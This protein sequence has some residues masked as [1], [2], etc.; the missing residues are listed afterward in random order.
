MGFFFFA[1]VAVRQRDQLKSCQGNYSIGYPFQ[2]DPNLKTA[3]HLRPPKTHLPPPL[4]LE[5]NTMRYGHDTEKSQEKKNLAEN[6][7]IK[8]DGNENI[9]LINNFEIE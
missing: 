1:F 5:T 8:T 3:P 7:T 4:S 9:W 6:Y 2:K